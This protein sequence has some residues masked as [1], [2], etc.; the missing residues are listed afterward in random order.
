MIAPVGILVAVWLPVA[1]FFPYMSIFSI[2]L[3]CCDYELMSKYGEI[4]YKNV[5][6]RRGEYFEA[7]EKLDATGEEVVSFD[8]ISNIQRRIDSKGLVYTP[9]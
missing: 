8:L 2:R 7:E 3:M 6:L 9:F 4:V 5:P 1:S